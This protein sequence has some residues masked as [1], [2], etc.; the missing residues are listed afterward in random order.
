MSDARDDQETDL[1]K[2]DIYR[3]NTCGHEQE[4]DWELTAHV[5]DKEICSR[6]VCVICLMA[7]LDELGVGKMDK[8]AA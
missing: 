1:Q 4:G 7:K 5:N 8:L 3:C 6:S 2:P